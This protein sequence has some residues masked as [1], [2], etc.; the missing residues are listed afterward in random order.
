MDEMFHR[1]VNPTIKSALQ[2]APGGNR[3]RNK[4]M[5]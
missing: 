4:L 3:D 5:D 1:L 2:I